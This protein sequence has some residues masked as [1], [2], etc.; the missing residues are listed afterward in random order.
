MQVTCSISNLGYSEGFFFK[1]KIIL[2]FYQLA[3]YVNICMLMEPRVRINFKA[4]KSN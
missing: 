4:M 2:N 1:Y 3:F